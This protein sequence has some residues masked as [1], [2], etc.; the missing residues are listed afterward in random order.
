MIVHLHDFPKTIISNR[1][2][3]FVSTFW[4]HLFTLSGTKLH[5]SIA[6]HPKSNDQIEVLNRCLE[7]YLRAYILEKLMTPFKALYGRPPPSTSLHCKGNIAI[8]I[9]QAQFSNWIHL[10]WAS[11]LNLQVVQNRMKSLENAHMYDISF[12]EGDLVLVKFRPYRKHSI[13]TRSNQ[14]LAKK[15]AMVHSPSLM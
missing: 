10:I 9:V 14:K 4:T 5:F 6:W 12:K 15:N 3:M 8:P 2:N 7:K 13:A 1:G 11:Q